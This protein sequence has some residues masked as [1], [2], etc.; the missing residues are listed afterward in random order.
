MQHSQDDRQFHLVRVGEDEGVLGAMP[1]RIE[2][3]G[4]HM[5]VGLSDQSTVGQVVVRPFPPGVPDMHGFGKDVVVDH[6]GE[7][8]EKSHKQNDVSPT[9]NRVNRRPM[10][11]VWYALTRRTSP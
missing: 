2:S 9:V 3:E 10:Q 6:T 8:G 1:I 11:K 7:H 4:I 5:T